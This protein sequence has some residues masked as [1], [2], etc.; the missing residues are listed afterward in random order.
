MHLGKN[1]KATVPQHAVLLK[2]QG[3]TFSSGSENSSSRVPQNSRGTPLGPKNRK[4]HGMLKVFS[5]F[6]QKVKNLG[7]CST[8]LYAKYADNINAKTTFYQNKMSRQHR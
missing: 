3:K 6:D 5:N 2:H 1:R 7:E 4:N 8:N